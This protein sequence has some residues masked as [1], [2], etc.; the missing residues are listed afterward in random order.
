MSDLG[1]GPGAWTAERLGI[2]LADA[3]GTPIPVADLA[4]LAVRRNPRRAHLVV[5]RVLGKHV[6]VDPHLACT[7]GRA[8][9][10]RVAGALAARPGTG[11]P[12]VLGYAETATALGHLVADA[13]PGAGYLHSTRRSAPPG[14]AVIRFEEAH[15]HATEHLLQPADPAMVPAGGPVV[16]VDDELTTGRTAVATI[17][18]LHE[19]HP[20]P[21]Y[22]VASL[23]DLRSDADR[24]ALAAVGASLGARID[25][26][27]LGA[28]RL[29]LPADVLRRAQR[30]AD[31]VNQ[32]DAPVVAVG[33][34]VQRLAP[35]WPA[36]LPEG[37]RHGFT[38]AHR[39]PFTLAV[40]RL[41][42]HVSDLL[43]SR[44]DVLV[45]GAEELMYAPLRLAAALAGRVDTPVRFSSTTR[46]P[47]LPVDDPGYAVRTRL[48][49]PAHDG[50]DGVRY[51]YNVAAGRHGVRFALVVLVVDDA[52]DTPDLWREDGL[53]AALRSAADRVTVV[54]LPVVPATSLA[55]VSA[56]AAAR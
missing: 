25:V 52:G 33:A 39:E 36:G 1:R 8:L 37:G 2:R 6:P 21:H 40:D 30:L 16:L 28:A 26:V 29:D 56:P 14:A 31:A 50:T 24:Q 13:L 5:S 11:A 17:R 18:A 27:A 7:A 4:G 44:G 23:L 45:L 48:T 53:V 34:P 12:L 19:L 51:A 49:F 46:S 42:G 15:S 9:A 38:T 55:A 47:V 35:R 3:P 10:R 22:V 43:P 32:P 54:V 41:A 20:R